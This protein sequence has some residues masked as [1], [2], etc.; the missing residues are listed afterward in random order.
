MKFAVNYSLKFETL[1]KQGLIDADLLKCPEWKGVV[2]A[3][4]RLKPVYVHFEIGVGNGGVSK[5]DFDLIKRMLAATATPHLN[6]HLVGNSALNPE[7]KADQNKQVQVWI[8]EMHILQEQVPGYRLVAENLPCSPDVPA[9]QIGSIPELITEAIM[10]VDADLLL[11][12]SH[13][14]ITAA[15]LGLDFKEQI[16]KLPVERLAELHITGIRPYRGY[17][18]DHFE[19]NPTDWEAAKWA[20]QQISCGNWREPKIV[21]FEYGGVGDVFGW[22][23]E[24]GVLQEQ[25]PQL[26]ALFCDGITA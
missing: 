22:R 15:N 10:A 16:A 1:Y 23:T 20:K 24:E 26:Y 18:T 25:V 6:C 12:L 17:L 7:K 5:L 3:S 14:R 4:L 9:S 2:N 19:L 13:A 21:A 11:D 8:N